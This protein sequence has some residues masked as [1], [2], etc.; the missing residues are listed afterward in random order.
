MWKIRLRV[1]LHLYLYLAISLSRLFVPLS[2]SLSL[3]LC[4]Y[5]DVSAKV[6]TCI[7]SENSKYRDP[8]RLPHVDSPAAR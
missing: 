5:K 3:S 4:L 7:A 2:P 8:A 1:P 6:S